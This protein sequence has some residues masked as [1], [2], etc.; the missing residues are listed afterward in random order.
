MSKAPDYFD[1][2]RL[3]VNVQEGL[4]DQHDYETLRWVYD[5][6]FDLALMDQYIEMHY[7]ELSKDIKGENESTD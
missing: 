5:S 2:A 7:V 3:M 4:T 1:L 6:R